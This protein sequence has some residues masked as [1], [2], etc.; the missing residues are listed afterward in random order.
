MAGRELHPWFQAAM[1]L[2]G[3][4]RG[5]FAVKYGTEE[6]RAWLTYFAELGWT[7]FAL[8]TL[9][10]GQSFTVPV[11]WPQHLPANWDPLKDAA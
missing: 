7:P 11:R 5:W 2:G 1:T 8:K 10:R 6:H 3:Q 9:E 4:T